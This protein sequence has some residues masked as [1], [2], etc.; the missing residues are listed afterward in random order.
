MGIQK[1]G[2]VKVIAEIFFVTHRLGLPP[3]VSSFPQR[4]QGIL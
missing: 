3:S 1:I 2:L 4:S